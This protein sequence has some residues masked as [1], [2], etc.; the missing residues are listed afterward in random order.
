[1]GLLDGPGVRTVVFMQG[2]PLRC[3]YCHNPAILTF[4][5]GIEHT[6]EQLLNKVKRFKSYYGDTGGVTVSGGE[7]LAQAEFLTEFFRLCQQNGIH[8]C[9]D[10]SGVGLG[11]D[12]AELLK[13]TNLVLLDI[14][15]TSAE[16]FKELTLVDKARTQPFYEALNNS[17]AEVWIRQVIMP[18]Y[19][20]NLEYLHTLANE[21]K[22]IHNIKKIEF[23]PYHTMAESYYEK[24]N[25]PYRLKGM[26][27]MD[28]NVCNELLKEF[29]KIYNH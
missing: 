27:A 11:G 10:T 28:A 12:Y 21:I 6:P 7:P 5:G 26:P 18:N 1:M 13:S 3:A 25:M 9:L 8:T 14:K 22:N 19:N 20:D 17:N 23:L 16:K 15:H 2:C 4:Q 24:L 29:L